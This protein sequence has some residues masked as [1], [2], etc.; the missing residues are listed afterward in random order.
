MA[1]K[2]VKINAN[3][4][5][6]NYFL[7]IRE[8]SFED[9]CLDY[10]D[11]YPLTKS[12][13]EKAQVAWQEAANIRE[14]QRQEA[15]AHRKAIEIERAKAELTAALE[16]VRSSLPKMLEQI[17]ERIERES[18]LVNKSFD[19]SEIDHPLVNGEWQLHFNDYECWTELSTET[20]NESPD[21]MRS[22]GSYSVWKT[23]ERGAGSYWTNSLAGNKEFFV[24]RA[25]TKDEPVPEVVYPHCTFDDLKE[26][27]V[28]RE[29]ALQKRQRTKEWVGEAEKA[30]ADTHSNMKWILT[31]MNYPLYLRICRAV[32]AAYQLNT[33][34]EINSAV[35][36]VLANLAYGFSNA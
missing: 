33:A 11:K 9:W 2:V 15:L 5:L 34:E 29:L 16:E 14:K 8:S 17:K 12:L 4:N 25:K 26:I 21:G 3:T 28:Y 27:M 36:R 10:S 22:G 24:S 13:R 18:E 35:K 20:Y 7:T 31:T 6:V 32:R 19:W 23:V 30:L 1:S